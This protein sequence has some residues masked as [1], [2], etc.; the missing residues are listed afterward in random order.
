[1]DYD[2]YAKKSAEEMHK[3][4]S[5]ADAKLR[6]IV[7]SR[8]GSRIESKRKDA[9]FSDMMQKTA[10]HCRSLDILYNYLAG[11]EDFIFPRILISHAIRQPVKIA[12]DH[13]IR[14]CASLKPENTPN[15]LTPFEK[16]LLKLDHLLPWHKTASSSKNTS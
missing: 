12:D 4:V 8:N 6:R 13:S 9:S 2:R 7:T 3:I 5:A 16:F 14:E 10:H 15:V 11:D 1:M